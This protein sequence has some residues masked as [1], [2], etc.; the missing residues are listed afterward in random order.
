MDETALSGVVEIV[1]TGD[2]IRAIYE[3]IYYLPG[4]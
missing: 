2:L 1:W 3:R 4:L